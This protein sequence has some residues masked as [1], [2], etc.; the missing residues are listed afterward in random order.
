MCGFHGNWPLISTIESVIGPAIEKRLLRIDGFL[1]QSFNLDSLLFIMP[2]EVPYFFGKYRSCDDTEDSGNT[3]QGA[4]A[5]D[6]SSRHQA[7]IR[8]CP[9]FIAL[10]PRFSYIES[11]NAHYSD[12]T[13]HPVRLQSHRVHLT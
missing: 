3:N 8:G 7:H 2:T 10:L 4:D 11:H 9:N 5:S 13:V 6:V 1:I 12:C